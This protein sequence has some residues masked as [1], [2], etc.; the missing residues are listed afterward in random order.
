MLIRLLW[1]W[2]AA[3]A[4]VIPAAA[5]DDPRLKHPTEWT[6]LQGPTDLMGMGPLSLN[7]RSPLQML[8]LTMTPRAPYPLKTGQIMVTQTFTWTNQ[9]SFKTGA[10]EIDGEIL[11]EGTSL[12]W[13]VTDDIQIGAEFGVFHRSGGFAD[14]FIEAF[15][16][17][18]GMT[19]AGRDR[20]ARDRFAVRLKHPDGSETVVTDDRSI[21]LEDAVLFAQATLLTERR[22]WATVAIGAQLKLPTGNANDLFD[23]QT[24]GGLY[25]SLAK[26]L[27]PEFVAYA[28]IGG[29]L[30]RPERFGGIE[31]VEAQWTGMATI[32]Y[33]VTEDFSILVQNLFV[34]GAA[35]NYDEFSELSYEVTLGFKAKLTRYTVLEFGLIENLIF[36]E[37]SPDFGVHIGLTFVQ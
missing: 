28:A 16:D 20:R 13:A 24:A 37:N 6:P 17:A 8:R 5:Q 33:R 4:L 34:S 9:W 14:G 15:H 11:R 23:G 1:G 21:S 35:K 2:S 25:V 19:Q 31:L 12:A 27:T 32:E 30:Y 26:T 10:Y 29:S 18:I 3:F 7:S 36:Y 22:S